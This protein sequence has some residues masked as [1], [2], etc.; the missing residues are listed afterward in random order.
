[1][2]YR[3][4]NKDDQAFNTKSNYSYLICRASLLA[5]YTFFFSVL[6]C[7]YILNP[8]PSF[9]RPICGNNSS[10]HS[11]YIDRVDCDSFFFSFFSSSSNVR[12]YCCRVF[13]PLILHLFGNVY[14]CTQTHNPI[15]LLAVSCISK[16]TAEWLLLM[17]FF[18]FRMKRLSFF[19]LSIL[20]S[21]DYG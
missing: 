1:M 6:T 5:R 12:W 2:K 4:T 11:N 21:T 16:Y 10:I 15:P 14:K 3:R 20:P 17:C 7:F 19:F 18:I 8:H 13:S 9:S